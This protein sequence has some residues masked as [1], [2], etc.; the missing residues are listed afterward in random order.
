MDIKFGVLKKGKSDV[1]ERI[2]SQKCWKAK[3]EL[4]FDYSHSPKVKSNTREEK[5]DRTH[6]W[7]V[8]AAGR[9]RWQC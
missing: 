2:L 5:R 8:T 1:K 7:R 6:R 9:I 3:S 4:K